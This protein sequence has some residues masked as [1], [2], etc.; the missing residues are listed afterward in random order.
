MEHD[1]FEK[2][3][4]G[5]VAGLR[6]GY[7]RLVADFGQAVITDHPHTSAARDA[8]WLRELRPRAGRSA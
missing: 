3:A 1:D 5:S 2:M 8:D 4:A 6:H 7:L